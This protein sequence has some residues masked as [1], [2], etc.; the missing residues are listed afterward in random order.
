MSTL[1]LYRGPSIE[2]KYLKRLGSQYS[3]LLL[4]GGAVALRAEPHDFIALQ[5]WLEKEAAAL[6]SFRAEPED[7]TMVDNMRGDIE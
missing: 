3:V 5:A 7:M 1:Q 2:M 4:V 6:K